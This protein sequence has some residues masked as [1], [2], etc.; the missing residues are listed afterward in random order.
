MRNF[1]FF[2]NFSAK[3]LFFFL[4]SSISIT[5]TC[6]CFCFLTFLCQAFENNWDICSGSRLLAPHP[7]LVLTHFFYDTR[8]FAAP[9]ATVRR[10]R[11][12]RYNTCKSQKRR[13]KNLIN[14]F[15]V[16]HDFA[17]G[18]EKLSIWWHSVAFPTQ[19]FRFRRHPRR[20]EIALAWQIL[21]L[22]A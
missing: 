5:N 11:R 18:F 7:K 8:L 9:N 4:C 6:F 21:N 14:C 19:Y 3:K 1:L 15:G 12:R 22:L 17:K 13:G 10:V 2:I 20:T 16:S